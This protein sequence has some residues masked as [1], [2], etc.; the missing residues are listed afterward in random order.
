MHIEKLFKNSRFQA[1]L[2]DEDNF[3]HINQRIYC[4]RC[5]TQQCLQKYFE[6]AKK[7]L[8]FKTL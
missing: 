6:Y 4:E 5:F 7:Q 3:S 8:N 2:Y 1:K